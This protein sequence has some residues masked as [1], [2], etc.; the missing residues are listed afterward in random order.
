MQAYGSDRLR[1]D[2][3]RWVLVSR[4]DKGWTP[5]TEKTHTSAEF[6]GTT[7]LWNEQYYEVALVEKLPQGGVRYIL[8]PWR[9]ELTMRVVDHYDAATEAARAEEHRKKIVR[10]KR[11]TITNF[12][13]LIV[14]HFP[15][16]V[17]KQMASELGL[18]A[19]R[20]TLLSILGVYSVVAALVLYAVAKIMAHEGLPGVCLIAL[21]LGIESS[22]RFFIVW[23]QNRPI[24]SVIGWIGYAIYYAITKRGPS[25]FAVE[26][27]WAVKVTEAPPDIALR[28]AFLM[29]EAFVTLLTPEEQQRI[30]SRFDYDYRRESGKVAAILLVGSVMG[31]ASSFYTGAIISGMAAT[32]LGLEQIVRLMAFRHGP[33]ASVLRFIAR[34]LVRKFL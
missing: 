10:E 32:A 26:K 17:Q 16:L 21:P 19:P 4:F 14:G 6:P 2:G 1:Q 9:D 23:T 34:P 8:D 18:L 31:L 5:R 15:A 7:I 29:R 25:P 27:G 20:I 24:G 11:R 28:D 3:A 13:A 33:A 30:A 12:L 22:I